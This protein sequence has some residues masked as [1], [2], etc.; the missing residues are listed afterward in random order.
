MNWK[1]YPTFGKY[2]EKING[3]DNPNKKNFIQILTQ[4]KSYLYWCYTQN[5]H[6]TN[7]CVKWI[8]DNLKE[9]EREL[10]INYREPYDPKEF[11]E[12][13]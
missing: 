12:T 6:V 8:W 4:K 11:E 5:M 10:L 7:S 9:K 1:D 2:R 13:E 3:E